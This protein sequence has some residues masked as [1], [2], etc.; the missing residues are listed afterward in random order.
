MSRLSNWWRAGVLALATAGFVPM[1]CAEA[2]QVKTQVPGYYRHMVGGFELTALYDG[3]IE[4]DAAILKNTPPQEVHKLLAY[5]FRKSP[6]ATAVNTYLVNTGRQLVLIDTGAGKAFGPG[7]GQVLANLQ[8]AGYQPDQVDAVLLTHLHGDHVAGLLDADGR[9]AFP[10]ATLYYA[11]KD[12]DFWL[13]P[14]IAAKAPEEAR[15]FF[16]IAQDMLAPYIAAGRTQTFDGTDVEILPG[17]RALATPGHTPGHTSFLLES[18]GE[19][20][21]VWGDIV[22]NVY[23]QLARPET[24]IEFD[25]DQKQAAATRKRV[26]DLAARERLMVSGMHLPF[27]GI[28]QIR[29]DRRG[30]YSWV[31]VDFAPVRK[32]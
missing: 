8:A 3:Q 29:A 17:I 14:E 16:K 11:K 4:L 6:M 24:T 20:L 1:A 5:A 32:D 22:H 31:P 13:N 23:V 25:I 19:R 27:P 7:L 9:P 12:A 18:A 15:G 2:P 21:L 10:K 28:G 26:L 30:R